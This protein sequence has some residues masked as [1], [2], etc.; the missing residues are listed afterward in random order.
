MASEV[1][2]LSDNLI[3]VSGL[4]NNISGLYINDAVITATVTDRSGVEVPGFAW[5]LTLTYIASSDGVYRGTVPYD[6]EF[7]NRQAYIIKLTINGGAGLRQYRE[8][9]VKAAIKAC[10]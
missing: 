6:V 2:V 10:A 1:Y 8:C 5:P 4:I 7:V 3:T 9:T